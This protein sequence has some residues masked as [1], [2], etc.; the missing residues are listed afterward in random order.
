MAQSLWCCFSQPTGHLASTPKWILDWT[1]P[2]RHHRD[3]QHGWLAQ[4]NNSIIIIW[5]K[6]QCSTHLTRRYPCSWMQWPAIQKIRHHTKR[7]WEDT[8]PHCTQDPW[9]LGGEA[10]PQRGRWVSALRP[11]VCH[12]HFPACKCTM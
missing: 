9:V 5:G 11:Q 2:I 3:W 4:I 6:R 7:I 8:Q 1:L 12:P 10:L